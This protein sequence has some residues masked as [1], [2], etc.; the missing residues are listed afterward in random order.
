MGEMVDFVKRQRNCFSE[1]AE[2]GHIELNGLGPTGL[3]RSDK[4]H[5]QARGAYET[6]SVIPLSPRRNAN[7][8]GSS[9]EIAQSVLH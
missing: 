4:F 3:S 7:R 9:S 1:T 6:I 5:L 2:G 8:R